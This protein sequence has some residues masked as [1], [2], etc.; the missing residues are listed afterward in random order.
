M[1]NI[2]NSQTSEVVDTATTRPEAFTVVTYLTA[3][4]GQ[5]HHCAPAAK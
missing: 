4:T 3:T 2:F 1:F 5:Q